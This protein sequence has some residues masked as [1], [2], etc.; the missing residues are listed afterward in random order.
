MVRSSRKK[1]RL[2]AAFADLPYNDYFEYFAPNYRLHI[3]P[4]NAPNENNEEYLRM[5]QYGS[6]TSV[7]G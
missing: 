6:C 5:I 4:S 1:V 7:P 2:T 3:E